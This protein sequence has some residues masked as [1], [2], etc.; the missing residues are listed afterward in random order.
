MN[1]S[2][3][4]GSS[5]YRR[6]LRRAC[7]LQFALAIGGMIA[8]TGIILLVLV[9]T[10]DDCPREPGRANRPTVACILRPVVP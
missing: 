5:E 2:D 6:E 1:R 3:W 7:M 10:L 8:A 4:P 9:S